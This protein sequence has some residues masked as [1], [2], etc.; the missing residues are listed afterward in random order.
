MAP[1]R[2]RRLRRLRSAWAAAVEAA[3]GGLQA[4]VQQVLGNFAAEDD[5]AVLLGQMHDLFAGVPPEHNLLSQQL[6]AHM[7]EMQLTRPPGPILEPH[8]HF[9]GRLQ[10]LGGCGC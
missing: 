8:L 2:R 4:L 6:M 7:L 1:A 3:G 9:L 5:A 10:G